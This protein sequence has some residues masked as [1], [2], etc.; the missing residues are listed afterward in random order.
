MGISSLLPQ[1]DRLATV[2]LLIGDWIGTPTVLNGKPYQSKVIWTYHLND[3][4]ISAD[5]WERNDN[6]VYFPAWKGILSFDV[7]DGTI[8]VN[9]FNHEGWSMQGKMSRVSSLEIHIIYKAISPEGKI[10]EGK[11]VLTFAK[12]H[13]SFIWQFYYKDGEGSYIKYFEEHMTKSNP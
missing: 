9:S 6:W 4:I 7:T 11:D 10:M 5:T 12:H 8:T 13:Q 1:S 2:K 3:N